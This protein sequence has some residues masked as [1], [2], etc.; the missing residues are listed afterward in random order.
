ML[1][2]IEQA[3]KKSDSSTLGKVR[4][5]N[6]IIEYLNVLKPYEYS[7]AA[8]MRMKQL[9]KALDN[10][11]SKI[12]LIFVCGTNGKS[13]TI[14]FAAKL[15]KE[16]EFQ[17]GASYSTHLLNYNERIIS[18]FEAITNKTFTD[19]LNEVINIAEQENIS[20]TAYELLHMAA[21]AQFTK[22][23]LNVALLEVGYGGRLDALAAL[24]P[25][26]A[27]LTR[28]AED[29]VGLLGT[30]L[31]LIAFEMLEIAKPGTWF[32]SAEQSKIRLQKMKTIADNHHILW[33]MPIRKLSALPYI[34]E[35]LYG[36]IASL[37]ERIAQ[38]YVEDVKA[39][40]S[41][42]LRGNLLATEKGRRGR[43]TL[44]A[45]RNSELNPI[46]TLKGFWTEQ[47]DLLKGRFEFLDKE[48]P[49]ILLDNASNLDALN[50]L[51]LGIRL[52]HYQKPLKGLNIIMALSKAVDA[53]EA[54]KLIRYLLKKVS[55]Y[56][57]FID[58]P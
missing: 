42:F 21:L 4:N 45:K 53:Q 43:P 20:A 31:D 11:S 29:Q 30:D 1:T 52:L 7:E 40:F 28:V 34:Y 9:D 57:L 13:L 46:K 38:I 8:V 36:R 51:F 22:E 26:I 19:S 47:F 33:A 5:Y 55:G 23:K 37:G 16:E 25:K 49:S 15:L 3:R 54:L 41:P 50:N 39:K 2:S 27:A 44:E 12:D 32:I 24:S 10:V 18:N 58:L 6:E 14:H 35:Q 56:M 48:K 17:I